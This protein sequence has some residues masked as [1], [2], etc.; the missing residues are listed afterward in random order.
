MFDAVLN[1]GCRPVSPTAETKQDSTK[2]EEDKAAKPDVAEHDG[3]GHHAFAADPAVPPVDPVE[4]DMPEDHG[5]QRADPID[6][7]DGEENDGDVVVTSRGRPGR[8]EDV[9]SA[10]PIWTKVLV[11]ENESRLLVAALSIRRAVPL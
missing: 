8:D 10:L 11:P 5:Q 6:R 4:G 2:R 3:Y 7:C 1:R 9:N